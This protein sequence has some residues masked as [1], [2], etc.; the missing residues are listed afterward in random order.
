MVTM[1]KKQ[2]HDLNEELD[3][4]ESENGSV[5]DLVMPIVSL[6]VAAV[7]AM[8]YTGGQALGCWRSSIQPAWRVRKLQM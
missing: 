1:I 8:L 6:I 3:I 7:A 4:E 5:S 2:A